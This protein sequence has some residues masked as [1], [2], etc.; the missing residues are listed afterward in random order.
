MRE[1]RALLLAA[2]ATLAL[3]AAHHVYGALR[4]STPRLHHAV[5]VRALFPPPADEPP[6]DV[7]FELS[8]VLQMLA[9]IAAV[10]LGRSLRG[11]VA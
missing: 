7:V 5:V 3:F 9:A 11:G 4:Y 10:R 8:G 1:R 6:D 2:P